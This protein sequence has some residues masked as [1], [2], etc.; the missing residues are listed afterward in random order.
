MEQISLEHHKP[1][2]QLVLKELEKAR[3]GVKAEE[4]SGVEGLRTCG[5][6][7]P[8][9]RR[10]RAAEHAIDFPG[11]GH[12]WVLEPSVRDT[13]VGKM[14]GAEGTRERKVERFPEA[15]AFSKAG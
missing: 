4:A 15:K 11:K 6:R 14:G 2:R 5:E 8:Q 13:A 10:Q 7:K 3:R 9:L 1:R 12:P